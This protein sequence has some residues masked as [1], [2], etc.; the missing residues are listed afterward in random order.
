MA[1]LGLSIQME[2]GMHKFGQELEKWA[3]RQMTA[4]DNTCRS[5]LEAV[6]HNKDTI[7][8]LHAEREG[9]DG[10]YQQQVAE[11]EADR[12]AVQRLQEQLAAME[13]ELQQLPAELDAKMQA[14]EAK[15]AI[16]AGTL[17]DAAD[18]EA[19]RVQKLN[20]LNRGIGFFRQRLGLDFT[21]VAP[22]GLRVT[23]TYVDPADELRPFS[24]LVRVN[25][26]GVF[27]ISEV[28]PALEVDSLVAK[29]NQNND[30]SWFVQ[31]MR[32]RFKSLL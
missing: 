29:L 13:K 14:L 7:S 28:S 5:H 25:G 2:D 18:V 30:F 31:A 12:E 22:G 17:R 27:E 26:T 4:V 1:A 24:F 23:Y 6:R 9:L 3:G 21:Q 20:E 15:R 19:D 11:T 16:V 8:Q 10:L 32:R